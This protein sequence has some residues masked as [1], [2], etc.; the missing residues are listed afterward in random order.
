[1]C[2]DKLRV[3][4]SQDNAAQEEIERNNSLV[5]ALK[6][7]T[8]R[9]ADELAD[10][11]R[12]KDASARKNASLQEEVEKLKT[13]KE[14][15]EEE[16]SILRRDTHANLESTLAEVEETKKQVGSAELEKA[17]LESR[18]AEEREY[19]KSKIE[20]VIK[21]L[22]AANKRGEYLQSVIDEKEKQVKKM[23]TSQASITGEMMELQ[24]QISSMREDLH[25]AAEGLEAHA[26]RAEQSDLKCQEIEGKMTNMK[27]QM[28]SMRDQHQTDFEMLRQ[29]KDAAL[30]RVKQDRTATARKLSDSEF[31]RNELQTKFDSLG[32][33]FN[34]EQRRVAELEATISQ[35]TTSIGNLSVDLAETKKALSDRMGLATRLQTENMGIAAQQAEQAALIENALREAAASKE[36]A[37][38]LELKMQDAKAEMAR[39]KKI[40][41]DTVSEMKKM[42]QEVE[43][44]Q[45]EIESEKERSAL[46]FKAAVDAEKEAFTREIERIE[47][48]SKHKSR[49]A[50]QAVLEKEA[51][52]K[53]LS[54]RLADL[55][56]DVRSG[57][58]DHRK[59]FEVAQLQAKREAESRAQTHQL[60][61]MANRL[62]EAYRHIQRLQDEK[63]L[64]DHE[65][66]ALMQTQ[67][68]EGVN[69]EY[70][71]NV[72]VQYMSFRPGSSQQSRLIPVLSTLLQFSTRDM[73]DIKSASN[74]RRSSWTSWGTE[75]KDYKP[76]LDGKGQQL[77]QPRH[78]MIPPSPASALS[79]F[80][81]PPRASSFTLPHAME[82]ASSDS[83]AFASHATSESA[84]F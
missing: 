22:D 24:K 6:E 70:L 15:L 21:E 53:R 52:I 62:D 19:L 60:Q 77:Q 44:Q 3:A 65:L 67:R 28:D 57:D 8:S 20:T 10:H 33:A 69:M 40:K 59:I 64:H 39:S 36:K 55:E 50:I 12:E 34:R 23:A 84:D 1:M 7:N 4:E 37:H 71:K 30:Q 56:E 43:K 68:R 25:M 81:A 76:I 51:E 38:E 46:Q 31:A 45:L 35:Q 80:E 32:T 82:S 27:L 41:A 61:E 54:S 74:A 14:S 66:T 79:S 83:S 49:L 11:R 73:K 48:D 75:T 9:L 18:M 58:A 13:A 16:L 26:M 5:D 42:K 72:V 78:S 29:E 47:A 63:Q 17:Q 2:I